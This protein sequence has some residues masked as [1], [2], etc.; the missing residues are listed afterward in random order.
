[1]Y[2]ATCNPGTYNPVSGL[3]ENSVPQLSLNEYWGVEQTCS[4]SCFATSCNGYCPAN[5]GIL[6]LNEHFYLMLIFNL[7]GS[8]TYQPVG[9]PKTLTGVS[10]ELNIEPATLTDSEYLLKLEPGQFLGIK[11]GTFKVL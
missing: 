1:M 4:G 10:T 11:S 8:L 3:C 9:A 6:F 5:I 2:E 7:K